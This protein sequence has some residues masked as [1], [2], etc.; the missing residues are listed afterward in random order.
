MAGS[1][2]IVPEPCPSSPTSS[3]TSKRLTE[4]IVG[5]RL[6]R[7]VLRS[8]FVLRSVDPPIEAVNGAIVRSRPSRRASASSLAFD[9]RALPRH[10]PDDCRA[11]ALARAGEKPGI[12]RS[13]CSRRSNSSTARCSSPRRARRSARRCSWCAARRRFAPLDP[14]G[15]EPLDATREQFR[16]ALT[17]ENHTLK[18]ALTDPH[19][20]SGIGNAYSDEILHAARLSPLEADAR[21]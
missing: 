15:V 18:R 13:C 11:P 6:D 20:F 7:V 8:P 21:R 19:L 17:R 14:G 2:L 12:G 3:S 1:T 4:R 9:R 16:E 5:R 10:A